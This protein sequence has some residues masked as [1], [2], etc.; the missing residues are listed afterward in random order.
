MSN[1]GRTI[2]DFQGIFDPGNNC[3][4][5]EYLNE[6]RWKTAFRG[7]V[8]GLSEDVAIIRVDDPSGA[9]AA[10]EAHAAYRVDLSVEYSEYLATYHYTF[11][12]ADKHTW[13]VEELLTR[14]LDNISPLMDIYR[15]IRIARDLSRGLSCLHTQG[16]RHRDLKLDNCG[17]TE[18]GRAKIFDIGSVTSDP[19]FA[20]CSILTCAPETVRDSISSASEATDVW[21]LGATLFALRTGVYPFATPGDIEARDEITKQLKAGTVTTEEARRAKDVIDEKIRSRIASVDAEKILQLGIEERFDGEI[22]SLMRE[23]LA[24]RAEDRKHNARYFA[25]RWSDLVSSFDH[26]DVVPGPKLKEV[27]A[28]LESVMKGDFCLTEKQIDRMVYSLGKINEK[29]DKELIDRLAIESKRKMV[30]VEKKKREFYL[31]TG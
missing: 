3:T 5:K 18:D 20:H 30:E 16:L 28:F 10:D 15:F 14:T 9:Q 26:D 21:A 19:D 4:L 27:R 17:L 2:K 6:G 12:G 13:F 1:H 31:L 23:M 7:N 22:E 29:D 25:D 24:F 8:L 11:R